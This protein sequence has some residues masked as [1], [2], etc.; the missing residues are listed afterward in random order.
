MCALCDEILEG[1]QAL[2]EPAGI[3]VA[4]EVPPGV[5]LRGDALLLRRLLLNLLDNA[6]KYNQAGSWIRVA[7]SC[8]A[9]G[10]TLWVENSGPGIPEGDHAQPFE[11]FYRVDASRRR[12]T[13]GAGLGLSICREVALLDGGQIRLQGSS[14]VKTCFEVVLP[15]DLAAGAAPPCRMRTGAPVG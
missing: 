7:A 11:R 4:G 2:A 12:E 10:V 1:F 8:G 3:R 14:S 6:L 9:Q 15:V 13:G 5:C